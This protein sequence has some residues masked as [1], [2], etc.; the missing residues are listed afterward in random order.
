M[1]EKGH[2]FGKEGQKKLLGTELHADKGLLEGHNGIV[3]SATTVTVSVPK[4]SSM[5][6]V[7]R[8][9]GVFFVTDVSE[10]LCMF[11]TFVVLIKT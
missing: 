2:V 9:K 10:G 4:L 7:G 1:K 11:S 6:T 8:K 3:N 5:V